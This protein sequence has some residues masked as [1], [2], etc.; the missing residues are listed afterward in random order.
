MKKNAAEKCRRRVATSRTIATATARN[1]IL[2]LP[3]NPENS[4]APFFIFIPNIGI[5]LTSSRESTTEIRGEAIA[6]NEGL[7]QD[8]DAS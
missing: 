4:L 7:S 1:I 3:C 6:T 5:S 2:N 8:T